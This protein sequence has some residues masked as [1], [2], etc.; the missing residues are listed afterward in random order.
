[1][2]PLL[3]QSIALGGPCSDLVGSISS[4]YNKIVIDM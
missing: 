1:M 2:G 3:G 4:F